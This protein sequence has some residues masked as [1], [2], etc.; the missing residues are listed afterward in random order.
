MT[1]DARRVIAALGLEPLATEGGLF[2]QTWQS[3]ERNAD[4][5]PLGTSILAAFT[6]DDDSFS[7]MHRLPNTEIWHAAYGH[8][9]TL[10]LLF[11]DGTSAEPVLGR[12]VLQGQQLQIV[13]PGGTWM[14]ASL[15]PGGSF[16][17]FGCT[18]AP[19]F[20]EAD[21]EGADGVDLVARWPQHH[22]RIRSLVREG[23]PLSITGP[24]KTVFD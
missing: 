20:V 19:G 10:L 17:V 16:G 13:V 21:Y 24:L 6:D 14:G 7:A 5:H 15:A 8:P 4:G 23:A 2:R 3:P 11:S 9:I 18:M 22:A 1:D 12:N